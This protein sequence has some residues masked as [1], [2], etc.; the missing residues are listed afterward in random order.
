MRMKQGLGS[1]PMGLWPPKA[2]L[3]TVITYDDDD[4]MLN[5]VE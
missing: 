2:Y 5:A 4:F 1:W 3:V